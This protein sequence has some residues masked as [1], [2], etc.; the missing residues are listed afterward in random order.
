MLK[1]EDLTEG[2]KH[3][4]AASIFGTDELGRF[5]YYHTLSDGEGWCPHHPGVSDHD[6]TTFLAKGGVL[7]D[8]SVEVPPRAP[9]TG[10]CQDCEEFL[11]PVVSST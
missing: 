11:S 8:E 5:H 3:A 10:P 9:C 1:A 7:P 6:L 2:Q 4:V